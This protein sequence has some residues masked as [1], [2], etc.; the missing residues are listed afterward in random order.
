MRHFLAVKLALRMTVD[1]DDS[2]GQDSDI[3]KPRLF[4]RGKKKPDRKQPIPGDVDEPAIEIPEKKC[5]TEDEK[6][7]PSLSPEE[8]TMRQNIDAV[9]DAVVDGIS[10]NLSQEDNKR[11]EGSFDNARAR[12][13][14]YM[15][16]M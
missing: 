16:R 15:Y 8:N 1:G 10:L 13:H 7:G 5:C 14:A 4:I 3:I 2:Y 12:L 6:G 9:N 11:I